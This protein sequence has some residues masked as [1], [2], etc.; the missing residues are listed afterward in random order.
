[1]KF[2]SAVYSDISHLLRLENESFST[3]KLNQRNFRELIKKSSADVIVIEKNAEIIACAV[4][5]FRKKS[6]V[7]RIYSLAVT[8]TFRHQGIASKLCQ[9]IELQAKKRGCSS[10]IL[11]VRTDNAPAIEFYKKQ[12]YHAFGIYQ[13]FYTDGLDAI[14]MRKLLTKTDHHQ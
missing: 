2:R 14:R 11:E 5:L 9:Y 12:D 1:M 8:K 3:D 6:T 4:I 7:A 13:H 10:L